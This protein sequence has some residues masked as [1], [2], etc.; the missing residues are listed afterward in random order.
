VVSVRRSK[1][2]NTSEPR[3]RCGEVLA[4]RYE[5]V[6]ALGQGGMGAVY[7]ALDR[8]LDEPVALKLL[9]P[10]LSSDP[11]YRQHLRQEVRLAR[12]VSHP[13][14]CRVHDL[15][16]HGDQLFVTMELLRGPSLR[17][18]MRSIAASETEPMSLGRK[19]DLVVQLAAALAAAHQAGIVHRD[20][21]PDNIIVEA[22][23]AVLADFGVA[24]PIDV[25]SV[26][27]MVV[28]TPDYIAPEVLCGSAAEPASDIY[29]CGVVAYELLAGRR[30]FVHG[31]IVAAVERARSGSYPHVPPLPER[32]APPLALAALD[33]VLARALAARPELRHES[34]GRM[35][36]AIAFAARGARDA[37]SMP[38]SSVEVSDTSETID[39]TALPESTLSRVVTALVFRRADTPASNPLELTI[40]ETGEFELLERAV[41]KLGGTLVA[42]A[43]GELLAL[44]GAPRALGDDVVRAARAAH[45]LIAGARGRVGLHTGRVALGTGRGGTRAQ[46]EAVEGARRLASEAAAGEVLASAVTARHLLGRFT[47]EAASAS[48]HRVLPNMISDA[49]SYDLPPLRGRAGE[50]ARLERMVLEAFEERSARVALVVGPAGVGKSRLRLEIERRLAER[51]EAEWLIARADPL[52]GGVPLGL[53][54]NASREW[55]E[56]AQSCAAGGRPAA[57]AA[58]RRWLESRASARPVVIALDDLHWADDASREF[59]A[60]LRRDLAQ[61]PVAILLFSRSG[62]DTPELPLDVDLSLSLPPIDPAAG[63]EIAR[64]LAPNIPHD[65]IDDMIV[66]AGGNPFFLEELARHAA[67]SPS[68]PNE[69]PA[70]VELVIQARLDQLPRPARRLICAASVIGREFDRAALESTLVIE[71]M[72]G[73]TIDR[74]LVEL[75]RRQIIT[76][77]GSLGIAT[78]SGKAVER[79]A[80]HHVL[81]RDVAYSQLDDATRRRAHAAAAS[82]LEGRRT[83]SR[84]DPTLL[85]AL[86]QH[87]DAAGQREAAR[88]AYRAS[89]ELALALAAYREANQ[90]LARAEQLAGTDLD[91]ALL[92]LRGDALLQLDSSAAIDRFERALALVET[93]LQR[94][95][96]LHK[97]GTAASNRADNATAIDYFEHGL[98]MLGPA[99][100]LDAADRATKLVAARLLAMLGWVIGYEIGDHRRGLPYAERAVALFERTGDLL[101]LAGGLSRLAANYL[102][103]GRWHDRLRCNLRH[104]EIAETLDDIDRQMAA[105]I[106]L[107]V[108]YHSLGRIDTA[109][110][111]TR[112][113]LELSIRSGRATSRALAHNNLGLI[114]CDAGEDA[115]ARVE[116]EEAQAQAERAGYTRFLFETLQTVAILD[117]R[118]GEL[119][120]AEE[121]ARRAV[122]FA[123]EASSPLNEGIAARILAGVIA[124]TAGREVEVQVLLARARALVAG[125]DYEGARTQALEA[126]HAA[127]AGNV[128]ALRLREEARQVFERLGAQLDLARLDDLD[129]VR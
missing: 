128:E 43:P 98:A 44:F 112:R 72:S 127:R 18:V 49:E 51:R 28:G 63:R 102:R 123:R 124:H 86:A 96:L 105:H 13:N 24:S 41:T 42:P 81:I 34:V 89:G 76:V 62:P 120:R 107:G 84:R 40:E 99:D 15:G 97:L 25:D 80:F 114:L 37:V 60:G 125:D 38:R 92:E 55:F 101:E 119:A 10:E 59:L 68:L 31:G 36:E 115:R 94:A 52:G 21:K 58:A 129:D 7:E 8:D 17:T 11:D 46:G 12:R 122:D 88:D 32:S 111:H 78:P 3:P 121:H 74:A 39:Q 16:Q 23:R 30:P 50:V 48:G 35:A 109:L 65:A 27:D 9:H 29:S 77:L 45:A 108:N 2:L 95:G 14:V 116:L 33:S 26:R 69:L 70:S 106:N 20:V 57:F 90:A 83:R 56:A 61:V 47:T 91:A 93:P 6:R 103:A 66:R 5:V 19:I 82:H 104:L 53:L 113:G 64:R 73:E 100:Q 117:L 118:A 126:K 110:D 71:P 1:D 54:Q 85:L 79:Y 67:E 75:E 22:N 4:Q 87:H